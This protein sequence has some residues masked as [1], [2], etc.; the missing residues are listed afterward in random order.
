MGMRRN[1]GM[2]SAAMALAAGALAACMANGLADAE[3][4]P[5]AD[6]GDA[7][8]PDD[9]AFDSISAKDAAPIDAAP[10]DAAPID[11]TPI[12]A[13]PGDAP[14]DAPPDDANVDAAPLGC[15]PA[16]TCQTALDVGSVSGDTNSTSLTVSG[17]TSKWIQVKVTENFI[18]LVL[19]RRLRVSAKLEPPA[20]ENF[21]LYA[22][23]DTG[24]D[25]TT[26]ACGQ[27]SDQSTSGAGREDTVTLSW[28]EGLL[29]SPP[30]DERIIS[31]EVRAASSA[32]D[33]GA[34]WTLTITG[35]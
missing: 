32:C 5:A 15:S 27:P 4:D 18:D 10:I 8:P 12:D 14:I 28:G 25:P 24:G 19:G 11:A 34:A 29:A 20:G 31:F 16:E 35:N 6:T 21:D 2:V 33:P 23:V 17:S 1:T 13:P 22:Y 7:S 3:L 9:A 26:R 30:N